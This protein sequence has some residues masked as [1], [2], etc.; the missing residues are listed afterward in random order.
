MTPAELL[1]RLGAEGISVSLHVDLDV[2]ADAEPKSETLSLIREHRTV[3]IEHLT[4]ER[5]GTSTG[6]V[7]QGLTLYGDLFHSL[8]FWAAQWSEL[9]LEHPDGVVLNARPEHITGAVGFHP[10]GVVYD[11][12]KA[13]L[14]TWGNVPY[15]ALVGKRDLKIWAIPVPE[16]EAA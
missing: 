16:Q 11:Q 3:L 15:T 12:T 7:S 5:V 14:V 6:L 1:N 2:E 8:M 10:W 13:V 9:R 4:Q